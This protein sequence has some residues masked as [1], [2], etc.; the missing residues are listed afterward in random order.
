ML[1]P[2]AKAVHDAFAGGPSLDQRGVAGAREWWA[3]TIAAPPDPP[4]ERLDI[5]DR[6]VAGTKVRVYRPA[7]QSKLPA[8]LFIHGGGW[9]LGDIDFT[10]HTCR[11]LALAASAGVVSVEY[12]LSPEAVFS[13]PLD[14]CIGVLKELA[15]DGKAAVDLDVSALC[16]AGESSGGQLAA[17]T[18]VRATELGLPVHLQLLVCP[19]IDPA[20]DTASWHEFGEEYSPATRQMSW[21]W[22]LYT[23][24]LEVRESEPLVNLTLDRDLSRL[25]E[26]IILTAEYDP[27]RDEGEEYGRR[28]GQAGVRTDVRRLAGQMHTVFALAKAVDA[29]N[30]ALQ[31]TGRDVGRKLRNQANWRQ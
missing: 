31:Q 16:V 28:L 27:L 24:S 3:E 13:A 19:V 6:T 4:D 12:R 11:Q 1:D 14:D 26:T 17:A 23:G 9:V 18:C 5:E 21:M 30:E 25:P 22:D 20:M 2:Q 8:I 10:D 7:G 15:G 29:C